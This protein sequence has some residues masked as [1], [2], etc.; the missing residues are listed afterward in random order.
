MY[1]TITHGNA[2]VPDK[3]QDP[4]NQWQWSPHYA[5]WKASL[6]C[7]YFLWYGWLPLDLTLST[8][9]RRHLA[10]CVLML[11]LLLVYLLLWHFNKY[12]YNFNGRFHYH[13]NYLTASL[14]ASSSCCLSKLDCYIHVYRSKCLSNLRNSIKRSSISRQ[15]VVSIRFESNVSHRRKDQWGC[16]IYF[17]CNLLC[18]VAR[19][20]VIRGRHQ[21]LWGVPDR[22]PLRRDCNDQVPALSGSQ[23]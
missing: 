20:K 15:I 10:I 19:N 5:I 2:S 12:Y 11:V 14:R 9:R 3:G 17:W 7:V 4:G 16:P 1:D 23:K 21:N 6:V 8:V 18:K 13:Q 22:S